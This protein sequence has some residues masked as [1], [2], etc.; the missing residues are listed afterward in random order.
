MDLLLSTDGLLKGSTL[1][2]PDCGLFKQ[3]LLWSN[4]TAT[5]FVEIKAKVV[6]APVMRLS[7]FSKIVD[8]ACE[9][10]T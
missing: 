5:T 10:P 1:S 7:D 3:S 2:G 8:V 4:I 6:S 9:A